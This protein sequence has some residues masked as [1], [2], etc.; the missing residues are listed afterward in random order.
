MFTDVIKRWERSNALLFTTESLSL[1]TLFK[2]M[3]AQNHRVLVM[4]AL[5]TVK[6]PLH[7]LEAKYPEELRPIHCL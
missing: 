1:Q 5:E 2:H 4:W 7:V 6:A 3:G